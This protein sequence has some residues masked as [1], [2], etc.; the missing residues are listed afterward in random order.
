[1]VSNSKVIAFFNFLNDE[2]HIVV[3]TIAFG[4]PLLMFIYAITIAR[5][6]LVDLFLQ[7]F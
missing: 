5:H 3:F 7:L 2:P 4:L 1:M 6:G